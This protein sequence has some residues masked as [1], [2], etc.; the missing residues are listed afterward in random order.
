MDPMGRCR[1]LRIVPVLIMFL[2]LALDCP[3][4]L[5]QAF[6]IGP[7]LVVQEAAEGSIRVGP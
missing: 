2:G 6:T 1:I 4:Q 3:I 5:H 7:P